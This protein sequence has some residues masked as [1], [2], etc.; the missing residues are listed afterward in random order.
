MLKCVVLA[1]CCALIVATVLRLED[2]SAT[3]AAAG[4]DKNF[5]AAHE[6]VLPTALVDE[7]TASLPRLANPTARCPKTGRR[8]EHSWWMPLRDEAGAP[9]A[10]RSA[11]ELAVLLVFEA[12]F[13]QRMLEQ[14]VGARSGGH[15]EHEHAL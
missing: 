10:P 4:L 15:G 7:V 3:W 12:T 5:F 13:G 14:V 9:S 8:Q 2:H 11:V 6:A 1:R